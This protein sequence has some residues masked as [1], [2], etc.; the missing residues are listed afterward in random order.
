MTPVSVTPSTNTF[1]AKKKM[2]R[3]GRV[4]RIEA[5]IW[6]LA[7]IPRESWVSC[8]REIARVQASGL[9]PANSSGL[10]KSFQQ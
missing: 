8:C 6:R 7:R 4:N 3:T 1:W 2:I 10:K 9:L 5:A